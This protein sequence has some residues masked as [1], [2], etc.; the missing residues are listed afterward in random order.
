MK[1][2]LDLYDFRD[3]FEKSRR[4]DS[5]SYE[6]L[7][8]LFEFLEEEERSLGIENELDVIGICGDWSEYGSLEEFQKDYSGYESIIEI[9]RATIVIMVD[10]ERFIIRQF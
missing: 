6:G 3:A 2:T 1:K 8:V 5:F 4:T 10:D 9:E 7:A